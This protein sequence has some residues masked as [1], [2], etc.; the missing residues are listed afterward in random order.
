MASKDHTP[1]DIAIIGLSCRF[2]GA[3]N[4]EAF[5]DLL[6]K[7]G[8]AITE[9]PP[10]RFDVDA[11][12][13]PD[14]DKP[15][16]IT[17]RY[18]GFLAP[19]DEFDP[20]FFGIPPR[21]TDAID[22][23]QRLALEV[24]WEALEDAA[25]APGTLKNR[26]VGVFVGVSEI[27]YA[28][29]AFQVP[30]QIDLY[31]GTGN[32]QAFVAGRIAYVLGVQGQTQSINTACSS[33]LVAIHTACQALRLEECELALAGGVHVILGPHNYIFLSRAKALSPD[34]RSK[35]FDADADG[36]SRAEGCGM[37]VLKRLADARR[38]NDNV[39]GVIRASVVNNDG[40]SGGL[41]VPNVAAQ[42]R[43][44]RSALQRACLHPGQVSY[45]EAHGT[46]TILGDPL[47]LQ[48]AGKVYGPDRNHPLYIGSVKGN[49][50]HS[51]A[52]AGIAGLIKV[53]LS[54][55]HGRIPGHIYFKTPNPRIPWHKLP[56]R[57]VTET[58][59]WSPGPRIAGISSFGMSGTN[60][61]LLVEAC[62]EKTPPA[63]DTAQ[64]PVHILPFSAKTGPALTDLASRYGEW[65]GRNPDTPLADICFTAATGRDHFAHRAAI[66]VETREQLTERLAQPIQT[67]TQIP[68]GQ[69][70]FTG[71]SRHSPGVVMLFTG[72][73]SQYSG[74]GQ[75]LYDTQAVF[76]RVL[77]RCASILKPLL[78][79]PLHSL[80]FD[81]AHGE[82]LNRTRYTQPA[83]FSLE[84]ALYKWWRSVGIEPDV[85]M[86]HGLGE[87]A[88]AFAAGVFSLE[89]VLRLITE[90]ARL[91]DGLPP[92]GAMAAVFAGPADVEAA[93]T[94]TGV[95]IAA[96]NGAHQVVSGPEAEVGT[97]AGKFEQ[98]GV[99]IQRLQ[100][101]H[102]FHSAL[103]APILDEFADFAA[104]I[105]YRSPRCTLISNLTGNAFAPGEV[106]DSAYWCRHS[107]EPVLFA[108]NCTAVAELGGHNLLEIGPHP[109]LTAMAL[110]SWPDDESPAVAGSLRRKADDN[111]QLGEA[112]ARLYVAGADPDWKAWDAHWSRRKVNLPTYPFQRQRYWAPSGKQGK[113]GTLVK[114][115][116]PGRK[117]NDTTSA[118]PIFPENEET[119]IQKL[120]ILPLNE[121]RPLLIYH[122][123]QA[124]QGIMGLD[125][126]PNPETNFFDLGLDSLM[127]VELHDR[128]QDLI[129]GEKELS[130]A[131]ILKHPTL[132]RLADHLPLEIGGKGAP[133]QKDNTPLSAGQQALWFIYRDTPDSAA[134]NTG[135]LLRFDAGL[136]GDVL[137][138][139]LRR[140]TARHSLLQSRL[141]EVDGVPCQ[142]FDPGREPAF[143]QWDAADWDEETVMEKVR[144]VS[145]Q[146]FV[147]EERVFRVDGFLD[148]RQGPW[149]L[150]GLHHI[151]GDARS[152]AVLGQE[153]L[154]L[155]SAEAQDKKA[156]LP[157]LTV[158]YAD[159][160]QWEEE[161]L[162]SKTKEKMAAYW[163][164]QL[165]GGVSILQLPTDRPR[166]RVQTFNGASLRFTLP[167]E[168]TR[169][170]R[171]LARREQCTLFSVLFTAFQILLHR[172]T[173]QEEI[174]LGVP[175]STARS[176]PGFNDMVGYLVNPMVVRG[177]FPPGERTSF[178][179][180][181]AL[182]QTRILT[183][184][185]HQPYPFPLLM[186]QL[187]PERDP[188]Y[189]PLVQALFAY[190]TRA[191]I[192]K[193]FSAEGVAA[194]NIPLAQTEGQFDVSMTFDD[195]DQAL[196]GILSY[197]SDLFVPETVRRMS[198]HLQVLL[199]GIAHNP[200]GDIYSLPMLTQA[201]TRCLVEWNRTDRDYP[202]GETI[203][204]L[205]ER[206]VEKT[207]SAVAVVFEEERLTYRR[208]NERANQ[209]A[210]H[211]AVLMNRAQTGTRNPRTRNQLIAIAVERSAEM[212]IGLLGILKAGGAYLPIDP[213]Y[214][215]ERIQYML[216][217]S[218]APL[219]LT[220]SRLKAHLSVDMPSYEV[221]CLDE[222]GFQSQPTTNPVVNR[223]MTDLAYVIYTSGSTGK[224]KG[225][226]IEHKGLVNL[227]RSQIDTFRLLPESRVL[228]FASFSFDASVSEITTTLLSGAALYLPSKYILLDPTDFTVMMA[229]EKI[230]HVTLP[231][232]FL[233]NLS[234]PALPPVLPD[235][236][237]LVV[238]GEACPAEL[239]GQWA[240][241]VRFINA[242]GPTENSVC[243]SMAVCSPNPDVSVHIGRPIP[244]IRIYI[245]D[246]RFRPTPPGIPG[247][248]S[249]AGVGLARGYLNRPGLTAEKFVE[250]E[251]F[252]RKERIYKT[253][254]LARLRP[255]G[256]LEYMGRLDHQV[257]VRGFRIELGEIEA[258]LGQQAFVREAVVT[259][260]EAE[261]DR[262]LVAYFT[263]ADDVPD[264]ESNL[265]PADLR[266]LLNLQLPDYMIPNYFIVLDKLP[267]TPNG[268]IDREALPA[269]ELKTVTGD[270]PATATEEI[271][272]GLWSKLF[273]GATIN[274]HADFFDL[275]GHSLTATLLTARIRDGFQV[276]LPVRAVFDH[277]QLADLATVVE[278]AGGT[279]GP[280]P[281]RK[282]PDAATQIVSFAQQ[283]LWFLDR[284]DGNKSGVYNMPTALQLSGD[285]NIE[286][287]QQG[288]QWLV[289]RHDALRSSFPDQGGD[290]VVQ[291]QAPSEREVLAI[292][293]L[294]RLASAEQD[295]AVRSRTGRHA[296]EPFDLSR[297]PLFRADLL[298]LGNV[299]SVL[300]LNMHHIISDAWS[301]GV[302]IRDLQ[303]AY[304]A[305]AKSRE[306]DLPP[307]T[308]QYGDYAA[309][310]RNWLQGEV[311]QQ[312]EA[313]WHQQLANAPE[314]LE[315]PIDKPRPPRQSYRGA[316]HYHRIS[317]AL[318]NDLIGLSRKLN[319]SLFMTL[320]ST[321]YILLSRYCR[322]DD[323][324]V[325]SPIANRT[326]SD[327][328]DTIGFF[329]NT[330]V[331]RGR[332]HSDQ[333]VTD[334]LLETRKT[335]LAAYAHQDIPFEMLV[336]RLQP[337]RTLSHSPLFQVVLG[338][339]NNDPVSL[340]LPGIE[341]TILP[342]DFPVSKFDLS[343]NAEE[344]NGELHCWWE[345]AADLFHASTIHRMAGHFEVLLKAIVDNPEQSVGH[346]P[347]L[348][349]RERDT[350]LAWNNTAADYPEDN[351][352][353]DLFERQV[354]K[355]PDSIAVVFEGSR[356][357]YRQ[358]NEKANQL[359]HYLSM[360]R[361]TVHMPDNPLIAIAVERSPETIV[362]VLGI[363]KAGGAYVPIDPDYPES[364]IRYVLKDCAAPLLLT[365]SH[366][367]EK[368]RL[369]LK[370]M[371]P[372]CLPVYLDEIDFSGLSLGNPGYKLK[373]TDL[374]YINYTS[375]ST[376]QPKGVSIPHRAVVRLVKNT[377]YARLDSKQTFLQY[378]PISFD[379]ATLEIWG[380]L[381][382]SAKLVVV[383]AR[384]ND[385]ASLAAVLSREK[386]T[387]LWLTSSLFNIMLEE[388]PEALRGVKQL[389]TGGE[390]LSVSH[391]EKALR[392]LPD[393]QLINGY[394]PTENTTFTCC[395]PI[396]D[397]ADGNSI[398]IGRPIA[399]TQVFIVDQNLQPVPAGVP[400]EL[401]AGG[402]G[403]ARGY[404]NRPGLTREKFI[405]VELFGKT[406]RIY[407]T[408]DLARLLP[409]GD[410]EF[411]GR[412]DH[413]V[414]LRGFRI[415][416]GEIEAV[417]GQLPFV[418]EA[419][420]A[421]HGADGD[422]RLVAYLT[423]AGS[424]G[425]ESLIEPGEV[426]SRLKSQLPDYMIPSHFMVLERLPLTSNGKIDRKALPVPRPETVTEDKPATPTEALL[427]GLW[428]KILR[429]DTINRH[430][431]FFDLGGHSLSATRLI[432]RIRDN[433]QV[434]L[435]VSAVFEHP[436]LNDLARAIETT[437]RTV[438]LPPI[439]K[440]PDD[441]PTVL[442]F[443][444][445]RLW[446][447]NELEDSDAGVY[448]MPAALKLSGE[449]NVEALQRSLQWLVHRHDVLRSC[450]PTRAGQA[451][452]Q[453]HVPDER[454]VLT[455]HDLTKL[456]P[457]DQDEEIRNRA[458]RHARLSFD[459]TRGPL[460]KFDLL[461][462]PEQRSVLL[463]N[464]QHIISDGWSM[465]VFV[466]DWQHAYTAFAKGN[467]PDLAPLTIQYGDYAAWQRE[468]LQGGVL[469]RQV[470]YWH[471]QLAGAPELLE[472]PIDTPRP[473]VQ[474]YRGGRYFH[475]LSP[476]LSKRLTTLS[477]ELNVS[478]FM[479]LLTGFYILLSRYSR[480]DDVCVGTPIANRTHSSTDDLIGFFVNMLVLRG[481][482]QPG[483]SVAGLLAETRKTCLAAY[484]HQDIP[485]EMLVERLQ[486]ARSLSHSPLFQVMFGLQNNDPVSPDLPGVE[487]TPL[488]VDYPIARF[489]LSL[490]A[491]ERDGEVHCWWEY[492]TDLFHASTIQRMA[493]H[494]EVLLKAMVDDPAQSVSDLPLPPNGKLDR[495]KL[496]APD[497]SVVT[498]GYEAPSTPAEEIVAG[499][500]ADVLGM[501]RVG[502]HDDFF[503]LGGHSLL[504][505][506]LVNRVQDLFDV[507]IAVRDLFQAPTVAGITRTLI[508]HE[509]KKGQVDTIA[510]LQKEIDHMSDEEIKS[511]LGEM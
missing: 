408:G 81:P 459:L 365:Q 207:P 273:K 328:H 143:R 60:A 361:Q 109:V 495:K 403:L 407:K 234:A 102:A 501:A 479:T 196:S 123:Q 246:S 417:L 269:P 280:P 448:N 107:L 7:G 480:M 37:V 494:F 181:A 117:I 432:A 188:S 271:L 462:L 302:L 94:G 21:A 326:H 473:P 58:T 243:T 98:A 108:K 419:V 456:S 46:G 282:Q 471:R 230:S 217:D 388:H 148:A 14:P 153:L 193:R 313:Y 345:Y 324:C 78:D 257:K 427:A 56:F 166:P 9:I 368:D 441:A 438:S 492:A 238:A 31:S 397:Q 208:L 35:A 315:L 267:L 329:V 304:T 487:V 353:V 29:I 307:L 221:I 194:E 251:L 36:F 113:E 88:A 423:Q 12:Y 76:R 472:L 281:I 491:E 116:D 511:A 398:P 11:F 327:I 57:V 89:D 140:L 348:T 297:G 245:L 412:I 374:A 405:D 22:P 93:I 49:I 59:D 139:A 383:P 305:F 229:D 152:L 179:K 318:T 2:P 434:E 425:A 502:R 26:E 316:R 218:A 25:I 354:E 100:T 111:R 158:D 285:L 82:A 493:G 63:D 239:M 45:L 303:Q 356:L 19:V 96:F 442:S 164:R 44:L 413:Q 92:G 122:L 391:I 41:T 228:Q 474:S 463:L 335:C 247:E 114:Q 431:N 190:E 275:G 17:T 508:D 61:H 69:P 125:D 325:G 289:R 410:I 396:T 503:A 191:L 43:L 484:S 464:Y 418:K 440:R 341:T 72:Q 241:Q 197:N 266:E 66:V 333:S 70:I 38:D 386:I 15:G 343:L 299:K 64:R 486:P 376:G 334:L 220:Q 268:K 351:T 231:P 85:L 377:S 112:L 10:D 54:M 416:L 87:Y 213:T 161:L 223:C 310:Q 27:D 279:A 149:L 199:E 422:K 105:C 347:I 52:A 8:D 454:E 130:S 455:I 42:E 476:L 84:A 380:A 39:L 86:G 227:V 137:T 40:A 330:L 363:L 155:Y 34:G 233:N 336:E 160:L 5:W 372:D 364:R 255:D 83:L 435:Q 367:K 340:D 176:R 288:L 284:F 392:L 55:G 244:N 278:A 489:D 394:G 277:P 187:Q 274:R 317:P 171:V 294:T 249:V 253:G 387:I 437:I 323:L 468:W 301:M 120:Q 224:P 496:L 28:R 500:W 101:R 126:L 192:P 461:L 183:G 184:L 91:M 198:E 1:F 360:L 420:V 95:S 411:L 134:Y 118:V 235:L 321:F 115:A 175:T 308:I 293:D 272:A 236:K 206:Q 67:Q 270:K 393:T 262:R 498:Q 168:L 378:A 510:R 180:K 358:L 477:R 254:D 384:Q 466:R 450:F 402:A 306:P 80:L 47:E 460:F 127:A 103:L 48:A 252:G 505:V 465:S 312:Q 222:T 33:S 320:L 225:V 259:V 382:N 104:T 174:L 261:G 68:A 186:E 290:A 212:V 211:L 338:L 74:M 482:L 352:I 445:Q 499:I 311:L 298:L 141:G 258:V 159:F 436:R 509:P 178:R 50:G 296:V 401:V 145:Q 216:T 485:F 337:T 200:E 110:H 447:L 331:L 131:L 248:L 90:R 204:E 260:Y 453:V 429:R 97:V 147:L 195:D 144:Q 146:P 263:R 451:T 381:L 79:I 421:L 150:L 121:R 6:E 51:E 314:L 185:D 404:L 400:G 444:Q 157:A 128:I 203:V 430:D 371:Q 250:T 490:N 129:G 497:I 389:L 332:L 362:G 240:G 276:E 433:F 481:R 173:G 470:D 16:T 214:P 264:S 428:A 287:L 370:D 291:I 286:A 373:V 339:Q 177:S 458:A 18:G 300:L 469:Q 414:K 369:P 170:L 215:A 172:Y 395:Y 439:R 322:V 409:G 415:E 162:N 319:V 350:W 349:G 443:A 13:D 73:G 359:A 219:L 390:A 342:V 399:N 202:S 32:L 135:L 452:V 237:T 24:S 132:A 346:L 210:H 62:E 169:R 71:Q 138:R 478:L 4:P 205:F 124:L 242:Y 507:R 156:N 99:R 65:L 426:K 292:H 357:T 30:A 3:E 151:A 385:L 488:P 77:D 506:Q 119:L 446:F 379:A 189:P 366:M 344:R 457:G 424:P 375:G 209:L 133:G 75:G 295:E 106:P 355:T 182:N 265:K 20:A 309:W 167:P 467:E 475:S 449:L 256:N 154:S 504:V 53:I 406:R 201:E 163:Q 142:W 165:A 232:S 136:D 483:Q 283:R 23:Q 226:M